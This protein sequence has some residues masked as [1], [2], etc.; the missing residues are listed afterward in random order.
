MKTTSTLLLAA[1][2]MLA[3]NLSSKA[4]VTGTVFRDYNN[5]GTRETTNPNEPLATGIIVNAYN[6]SD[7]LIATVTTSGTTAPNYSF[8]ATGANSIAN[9]LAVRLEFIIPAA[10]GIGGSGINGTTAN[11]SVRFVSGGAAAVNINF[12][13]FNKNEYFQ[14]NPKVI[15]PRYLRGNAAP[16]STTD[17]VLNSFPYVYGQEKDGTTLSNAGVWVTA[18]IPANTQPPPAGYAPAPSS[19][20][21]QSQIGT[22]Y[23]LGWKSSTKTLYMG[24]YLRR[25][26]P[27]G[28]G[29]L[30]AIYFI[31]NPVA[32]T[33]TNN[34]QVYVNL[35]TLFSNGPGGVL[36]FT[37]ETNAAYDWNDDVAVKPLVGKRGLGDVEVNNKQDT[38]YTIGLNDRKLYAVPTSGSLTAATIK[39]YDFVSSI[40]T[41]TGV[42]AAQFANSEI[43]PFAIGINPRDNYVY[44]GGV[45]GDDGNI[46]VSA[47]IRMLVW[48]YD[49]SNGTTTLVLNQ[50]LGY[51]RSQNYGF[52]YAAAPIAIPATAPAGNNALF[53]AW[54]DAF[55]DATTSNISALQQPMLTDIAFDGDAMVLGFRDRF[56]DQTPVAGIADPGQAPYSRGNGEIVR[57]H[58]TAGT[59][60]LEAAG[61]S[62]DG[63]T[64]A[65]ITG[66]TVANTGPG[67]G[68]F[69]SQEW[70]SDGD[71]AEA[72]MGALLMIPGKDHIMSTAFDPLKVNQSNQLVFVNVNTNG[73]QTHSNITGLNVGAY[74]VYT[75]TQGTAA[76][77]MAKA[78]GIGDIEALFDA[79]SIEIGNRVW[80]DLNADG[81]QEP[82]EA[83]ISGVLLELVDAAGNPV[84]NDPVTAGIQATFVTTDANGNWYISSATGTDALGV[85]YGVALLPN[86]V[87]KVRLATTGAGNDWD[88]TANAGVGGPRAG[89]DL[90]GYNLTKSN[91][92]GVGQADYSDNDATI[93]SSIPEITVT[94]S[95][96]GQN[97]H[98]LDFGFTKL[99]SLGNKVW[100]DEGLGG[101]TAKD[102]I[103]NGTEPGVSGVVVMLY[104]NGAD[105]I[106][107]N[108][109]DVLVSSTI[110][111]SYGMYMFN[112]LQPSTGATTQYNVRV[113][114][115]ANY[116]L[117]TQTNTTDDNN[118][119]GAST[120][121]SD[122]N[123]LG[124][125]YSIDLSA[126]ENNPNIDAGLIIKTAPALSSIGNQVFFD[127]NGDGTNANGPT[128]PGVAGVTV[129]LYD[130]ATGNILAVTTTD[131]NGNYLFNNLPNGT[132]QV[133]FGAPAGTV[134]TTGTGTGVGTA[135]NSDPNPTTG[136]TGTITIS[137]A[138]TVIT[139]IDAGLKN[140]VKGALGDFVWNDNGIDANGVYDAT[141]R[142]NGI[143]DPGESGVAGV[144]M[145]LYGPGAD[146]Q[147]GGGDDVLL[148]TTTTDATGYY[149]F[150]NL[151]PAK[152]FVVATPPVGYGL[153]PKDATSA[154][155]DAKDSD[156]ASGVAAYPGSYITGVK[157]LLSTAA[158]VT[159][160]M[161]IDLGIYNTTNNLNSLGD[162]VWND[163]NKDGL[164]DAT[165][166]GV[167]N[168][169]VRLLNGAGTPVNNPATGKPY[170]VVTDSV[171]KY[172]FVDLPDG[173]YI[174]EFANI[175]A[176]YSF[177][178]QD[179]S[180]T[181]APG[182]GT[183]GTNDSDAKTTTG[184]TAV[185][186]IDPT[187]TNPASINLTN[188]DAG[189]S[190]GIP[191]GTASLGNRVWYDNGRA[192]DGS[193]TAINA[194]NNKQDAG[195]LG[196][197]NVKVE[198][199][200]GAGAVV[201]V[202][203]TSTPYVIYT[204][205]LGEYLFT[206][207]PA[208]D[209]TVRFSRF[210][211][212]YTSSTANFA[213]V[214]DAQDADAS[215]AGSS[216]TATT[217]ATT[218]V[219]T[220]QT[221]EDNLTVDMGIIP[222]AGTNSIGNF[223]WS[224][225]NS[226]GK[227]DAG[228][229]GVQGVTVTLYNNGPDGLP[230][231]AD[232]VI[233]GVTTTDNN[234]AYTFVGLADG[235]YNV[236]F[237][238][239]PAGFVYTDKD[240]A[241]STASDGSD[242]NVNIGRTGT[243]ALDP[244]SLSGVGVNEPN[245]DGGIISSRAALG[246]FVWLDTNG[247][248]IQQ[249]TEKGVSGVTVILYATDGTTV[250]ASTI[251]DAEGK[252]FFG[253]LLP[254]NYR[255]GF[256]DIPS[257]LTFTQQNAAGDNSN[258]TNSDA[259]PATP[260]AT[261]AITGVIN[262]VAGETD[263]TIDAGLKP[264]NPASVGNLVWNDKDG[265]G[266]QGA[267][268]PGVPGVIVTLK[269]AITNAVIGTAVTDGN[270]NYLINNI[271]AAV[272]GTSYYIE[273]SNLPA[274]ATFTTRTDN[275]TAA[276][277]SLGSDPNAAGRTSNFTLVPGQY[278]P[279]VDAG[280]N[281]IQLLPI[282]FASFT[283][284]P[285]G[286]QVGITWEVSVQQDVI[287]YEVQT[288]TDGRMFST[289]T[290]QANNGNLTGS[291]TAT[292]ATPVSGLNYYRIKVT[293]KAG[294][295]SYSEM[296]KVTF[297]KSGA[298]V[299][300]P[301][302]ANAGV[303][304]ISLTS[305]MTG[306]AATMSIITMDGKVVSTQALS[307]TNQTEQVNISNLASGNYIVSI[308]TATEVINTKLQ[309][310]K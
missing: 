94:T 13:V 131:A 47:N 187:S 265:N 73:V 290:T 232:D 191:A 31:N 85:N 93:V 78:N 26:T 254:G 62:K 194:N 77:A 23:G 190:Q 215:F 156:F 206:G 242:A 221:G 257:N 56:G 108:D 168:V 309:V 297:G 59:W 99:A 292:H 138:G 107:G 173:N 55:N 207:L 267:N 58:N 19:E 44:I 219:Y 39:S 76:N 153:S 205:A 218:G 303:V 115:P 271:P 8:P 15:V 103:Q 250:L 10:F 253:N 164:Q 124:V 127:T 240:K 126:G 24:S 163:V 3:F 186:A 169:T 6:A 81:I 147:V 286:S 288:A 177:T 220:L 258:N 30:G 214:D 37:R 167:P 17:V 46:G 229:L 64:G 110:T 50:F 91:S 45:Y 145:R 133:G 239:L 2:C 65:D 128:E 299:L 106:S 60:T 141:K 101:G 97:N 210:P 88:P 63:N 226:N 86:T 184:R 181:G 277:P 294:S 137:A 273:F 112:N 11:T 18:A 197:A 298:V 151:D 117:T 192:A 256:S 5:N 40:T 282:K 237:T 308:A 287:N 196:V 98:T 20:A 67:S 310:I 154:G 148:A 268:E 68:E 7:A 116:S 74:E 193:I 284:L 160:D 14:N 208:G 161:T 201:N 305:S 304:N 241:G 217:T 174:V 175:P 243:Y 200:D 36:G 224:D 105:G 166:A 82:G 228:E 90:V 165:E 301:N 53:Q 80:N 296:R 209:Y 66:S 248:G 155:G 211:A 121:G 195:E 4:Q 216:V 266:V 130:A 33:A 135:N 230:G 291:Y 114:P 140:D 96:Y 188:V 84:D 259:V 162:K 225:G 171:G 150:P 279:N 199:L 28:P 123:A 223:V 283:A 276:D 204:N 281:N 32:N 289:I 95:D 79:P 25:K 42:A 262:L 244:T 102:G 285:K 75:S 234:G 125:S 104:Q 129:T 280:I 255:V 70:A 118:T 212:G 57:V 27:L 119:T 172:R 261:T 306:K 43:H 87:Y 41:L 278:L 38:I 170:V 157:E 231:T 246:N 144:T 146:G 159:R 202:P 295:V 49:P 249:T 302:P 61:V 1:L 270:G 122:V 176:G 12:G 178:V 251:T 182:S 236:G 111:D 143:Q 300:Y 252:Y 22:V 275:V 120:T 152:Y 235:N 16:L 213:G 179:A 83:P 149:V 293:E 48:R 51:G 272:G 274:T 9:G 158:G 247:D 54:N 307:K 233:A 89:G 29:G 69:Y 132:Y 21:T 222:A 35:N 139:D 34:P 183:D 264:S 113:T 136:K 203:G 180:G 260:T 134:L 189:I 72:S 142:N 238:N 263:L 269:D 245:V 109:D 100:L 227:Q 185:I 92:V 71:V 198:L 52:G